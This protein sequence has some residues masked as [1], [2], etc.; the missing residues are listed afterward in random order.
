MYGIFLQ[1]TSSCTHTHVHICIANIK[2]LCKM[3]TT[4]KFNDWYIIEYSFNFF[5]CQDIFLIKSWWETNLAGCLGIGWYFKSLPSVIFIH[6]RSSL[7]LIFI[8]CVLWASFFPLMY[9]DEGFGTVLKFYDVVRSPEVDSK[10]LSNLFTSCTIVTASTFFFQPE[11]FKQQSKN[12][13]SFSRPRKEKRKGKPS[14]H[15]WKCSLA[16]IYLLS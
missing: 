7:G 1:L 2:Q 6:Q 4:D 9:K 13:L 11:S 5:I 8:S 12:F 3:L 15:F 10:S 14:F 16:L